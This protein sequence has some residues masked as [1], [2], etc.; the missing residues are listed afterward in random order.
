MIYLSIGSGTLD[1][2][3]RRGTSL[4]CCWKKSRLSL[5]SSLSQL[6][7][8]LSFCL[9]ISIP[10]LPYVSLSFSLSRTGPPETEHHSFVLLGLKKSCLA[11][12]LVWP[13]RLSV[14]FCW[15][16][17]GF[18]ILSLSPFFYFSPSFCL[19]F[20]SHYISFSFPLHLFLS[21][22]SLSLFLLLVIFFSSFSA[23]YIFLSWLSLRFSHLF[24]SSSVSCFCLG[25]VL[26]CVCRVGGWVGVG[27]CFLSL[28]L[29]F[30]LFI[31]TTAGFRL[32]HDCG[33]TFQSQQQTLWYSNLTLTTRRYVIKN[34]LLQLVPDVWV[35][36]WES[37]AT[38]PTSGSE[39]Q[40]KIHW[41]YSPM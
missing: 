41:L 12:F 5:S 25:H 7:L 18:P 15:L 1:W 40:W 11:A 17:L 32:K 33:F 3:T 34:L 10:S 36:E 14:W 22:S 27:G 4:F 19:S 8:Y 35:R 6:W 23:G 31:H 9:S 16:T 20:F 26:P 24:L 2:T 28:S 30:F 39:V 37:S 13:C 38:N 29:S 21:L